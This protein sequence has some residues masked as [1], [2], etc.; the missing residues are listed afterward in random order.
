MWVFDTNNTVGKKTCACCYPDDYP[1]I[2]FIWCDIEF[3]YRILRYEDLLL[4]IYTGTP[5]LEDTQYIEANF[6][7]LM[8]LRLGAICSLHCQ[9]EM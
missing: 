6:W 4:W 9:L 2:Q 3:Y 7:D 1:F 5:I 8:V